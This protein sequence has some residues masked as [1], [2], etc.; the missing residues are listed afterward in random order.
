MTAPAKAIGE[1]ATAL[2]AV[3]GAIA[4]GQ[5]DIM[6]EVVVTGGSGGALDGLAATVM[7]LF[8]PPGE[9]GA[10]ARLAEV[11]PPAA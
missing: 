5:I 4:E 3:A 7:N 11:A 8:R 2:V 10:G 6:P 1:S 9:N